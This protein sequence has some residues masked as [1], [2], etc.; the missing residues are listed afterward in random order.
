MHLPLA[1]VKRLKPLKKDYLADLTEVSISRRR[2]ALI[3][4]WEPSP[5]L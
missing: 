2:M 3:R 1:L 5:E 4:D